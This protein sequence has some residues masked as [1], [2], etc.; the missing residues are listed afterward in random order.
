AFDNGHYN[1]DVE[2]AS[3]QTLKLIVEEKKNKTDKPAGYTRA[4]YDNEL[5]NTYGRSANL[6]ASILEKRGKFSEALPYLQIAVETNN[7][8]NQQI[9][10][11]YTQLL[12]KVAP[13][14]VNRELENFI[15]AGHYTEAM[16]EQLRSRYHL[17]Y[18]TGFDEYFAKL[19][20]ESLKRL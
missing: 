17:K 2:N 10:E 16:K 8:S 7:R 15:K 6:H 4:R 18:A 20:A 12:E 14:K 19:E 11:N 9:N 13:D 1:D 3:L 5:N